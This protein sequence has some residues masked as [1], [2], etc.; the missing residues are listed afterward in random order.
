MANPLQS[1]NQQQ[2]VQYSQPEVSMKFFGLIMLS[3][4]SV[5]CNKSNE[6]GV[7]KQPEA[8]YVEEVKD[9]PNVGEINFATIKDSAG[10]SQNCDATL[11]FSKYLKSKNN[12]FMTYVRKTIQSNSQQLPLLKKL[13][14]GLDY[15][16]LAQI[17]ASIIKTTAFDATEVQV[18]EGDI[19]IGS[20]DGHYDAIFALKILAERDGCLDVEYK[21]LTFR[22]H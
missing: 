4:I 21:L 20:V 9:V 12:Y 18:A 6:E 15:Q 1:L 16:D 11:F 3:L 17:D 8:K 14:A 2:R 10:N 19:L 13:D 5:S 22:Y 7:N